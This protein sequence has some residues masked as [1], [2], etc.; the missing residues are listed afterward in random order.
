MPLLPSILKTGI[1][2][3]HSI[4]PTAEMDIG[5]VKKLYGEKLVLL[6]NIDTNLLFYGTEREIETVVKETIEVAAPGGGFILS[7]SGSIYSVKQIKGF[8]TMLKVA[9]EFGRYPISISK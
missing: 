6:G 2:G 9:K 3:L 1:T 5:L 7:S 8:L 4:E